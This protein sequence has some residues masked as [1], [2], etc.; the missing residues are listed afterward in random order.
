MMSKGYDVCHTSVVCTSKALGA[1]QRQ[2]DSKER[3]APVA[4]F[5]LLHIQHLKLLIYFLTFPITI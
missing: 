5:V 4:T 1:E 2:S 3:T